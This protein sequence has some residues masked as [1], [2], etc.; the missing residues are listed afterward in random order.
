MS[1]KKRN[2]SKA[3]IDESEIDWSGFMDECEKWRKII[4]SLHLPEEIL[5]DDDAF[6]A[7]M[8]ERGYS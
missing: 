8:K 2:E 3:R 4:H 1:K 7:A 6:D 5:D